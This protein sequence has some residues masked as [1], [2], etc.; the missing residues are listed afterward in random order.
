MAVNCSAL[1]IA[2]SSSNAGRR[3][4]FDRADSPDS[5]GAV[6]TSVGTGWSTV[7]AEPAPGVGEF[8]P[9][10]DCSASAAVDMGG[11]VA[12]LSGAGGASE[13]AACA[14]LTGIGSL[15]ATFN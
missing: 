14:G 8:A 1:L 9:V 4:D 12:R 10:F 5:R 2:S 7:V 13:T 11:I 6:T 3:S 15:A